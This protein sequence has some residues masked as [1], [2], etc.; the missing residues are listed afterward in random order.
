MEVNDFLHAPAALS[1]NVVGSNIIVGLQT[2]SVCP[3]STVFV[4][5]G[6]FKF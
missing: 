4:A 6:M 3:D 2:T 5:K 1:G